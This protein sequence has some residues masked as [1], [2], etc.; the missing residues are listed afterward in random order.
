[1]FQ[2]LIGWLQTFRMSFGRLFTPLFQFLIGWLQ[3]N[4]HYTM[5]NNISWRFQFLIGWLQTNWA[6]NT[7]LE[8][9]LLFQF[10]IGWLQTLKSIFFHLPMK[11]C[12]NSL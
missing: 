6:E 7:L 2:F 10:L 9:A 1:M 11:A 12:F 3:T 4:Y 8:L 5:D